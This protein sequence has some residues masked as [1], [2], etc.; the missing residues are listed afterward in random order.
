MAYD[1]LDKDGSGLVDINDMALAYDVSRHPEYLSGAKTKEQVLLELL[2]NFDVGGV[3][4]GIVTLEEFQNYYTNISASIDNDDYFE[5]MIRNAWHISGGE[6]QAANSS[7]KRVLVTMPDGTQRVEVIKDDVGLKANDKEDLMGRLKRQGLNPSSVGTSYGSESNKVQSRPSTSGGFRPSTVRPSTA[8]G[9]RPRTSNGRPKA[10]VGEPNAGIKMLVQRIKDAMKK[11][12]AHG[13]IGVQRLFRIMDD[14]GNKKLCLSE[15]KKGIREMNI[16]IGEPDVRKLFE[17]F[18]A[19][20]TGGINFEEFLQGIRDPLNE[21]RQQLVRKAFAILDRSETGEI[22]ID[23]IAGIYDASQHPEVIAKRKKPADVLK[24]FLDTFEVGGVKDGVVTMDEFMNYYANIGASIENDD[25]F[26]LMIRNAWHIAGGE[27]AAA[28]TANLRVKV[29]NSAGNERFVT[30]DDDLGL[31]RDDHAEIYNRLVAQGVK[32]VRAINGKTVKVAKG[33]NRNNDRVTA[34]ETVD[35]LE[36]FEMPAARG[37]PA[38][39]SSRPSTSG[40]YRSAPS[41][42]RPTEAAI[43]SEIHN[44]NLVQRVHHQI[45]AA[46]EQI[47]EEE[48]VQLKAQTLLEVLKVQLLSRGSAGI[49]DLQRRFIEM[50]IDGSKCL[51]MNEFRQA[52]I[53]NQLTFSEDQLKIL[54]DYFGKYQIATHYL[55]RKNY[56]NLLQN[57][58]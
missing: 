41:A 25:Y 55:H 22:D 1:V 14:D 19:D 18:D 5:L 47:K 34:G 21:R 10:P 11:R 29:T 13:F 43:A 58:F 28:N 46:A 2:D 54:F 17:H 37:R 24:E 15:F 49:I 16:D 44:G 40:N 36:N 57:V 31:H 50:D 27:G 7:N 53:K 42:G 35:G 8:G 20:G 30:I 9:S 39:F 26:E 3:K 56:F 48:K 6:G 4:D 32:D 12:G 38:R 45:E 23:D 52:M 33:T 51:D